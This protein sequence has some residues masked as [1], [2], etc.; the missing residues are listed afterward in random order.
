VG[1]IKL[2][3]FSFDGALFRSPEKPFWEEESWR[4]SLNSLSE[5]AVPERPS[6]DWWNKSVVDVAKQSIENPD[7]RAILLTQRVHKFSLRI[8]ELL[9]QSGLHFD[10]IYLPEGGSIEAFKLK[11]IRDIL[12]E[13]PSIRG[14]AIW[15]DDALTLRTFADWIESNGRSCIPHLVTV[16]PHDVDSRAPGR[17]A[18]DKITLDDLAG[19]PVGVV[20]ASTDG[21]V[22]WRK[23]GPS[24]S[25]WER[26]KPSAASD[27]GWG[28][29][30]PPERGLRVFRSLAAELMRQGGLVERLKSRIAS[31]VV[32]AARYKSKTKD[33]EGNVHYEY[34]DRQVANRH[35]QKAE[36]IEKL[37]KEVSDLRK[38]IKKDLSAKDAKTSLPA[39]AAALID[40]TCERVGNEGSA[41]EGHFGV[42]GWRKEHLTFSKGKAVFK[43]V[44]KSGVKHE[45]TVSDA[46]VVKLLRE[47]AKGK[48]DEDCLLNRDDFTVKPEHV[49][50]YLGAFDITA[51]DI[52]GFRANQ[53]M[54]RAL[55]EQ[56]RKGADLPHAR[57]KKDK[58]LKK[59]FA[60]ALKEVAGI[61]GHEKATLRSD[62]L[63]PGLEDKFMK[64]GTI[65]STFKEATKEATKT[66]GQNEDEAASELIKKSP[67]KKPPREDLKK[68][69]VD[70]EDSD[71]EADD[72]DLSRNVKKV[73]IRVAMAVRVALVARVALRYTVR[74][75]KTKPD[76]RT[77]RSKSKDDKSLLEWVKGKTFTNPETKK[78]VQFGS[79]PSEAQAR[80]RAKY[81]KGIE[82]EP[83]EEDDDFDPDPEEDDDF[84]DV[85]VE[86][87]ARPVEEQAPKEQA[88]N[89]KEQAPKEEAPKPKKEKTKQEIEREEERA[90]QLKADRINAE[91]Q[92]KAKYLGEARAFD[93]DTEDFVGDALDTVLESL[94]LEDSQE[95]VETLVSSRDSAIDEV[96]KG[97]LAIE[98]IPPDLKTIKKLLSRQKELS[99]AIAA[100]EKDPA[101]DPAE[102]AKS[103]EG[104][105]KKLDSN[106]QELQAD[107]SKFYV[108]AATKN[109]VRN[110]LTHIGDTSSPISSGDK[111]RTKK[112]VTRYR[113]MSSDDRA[114]AVE[115]FDSVRKDTDRAIE[116]LEERLSG[117]DANDENR[118]ADSE[119]LEGL[120][121][122]IGYLEADRQALE[123][124]SILEGDDL[125][126]SRVPKKTQSL[127]RA[128]K[129]SG[130]DVSD[131]VD[132]GLGL[133]NSKPEAREISNLIR[134]L[135]PEQMEAALEAIDPKLAAAWKKVND[136]DD[137]NDYIWP[138]SEIRNKQQRR[139]AEEAFDTYV[140]LLTDETLEDAAEENE[141]LKK[142]PVVKKKT[143]KKKPKAPEPTEGKPK[144][145]PYES[146]GIDALMDDLDIDTGFSDRKTSPKKGFVF[147][148]YPTWPTNESGGFDQ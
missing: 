14:V 53:E 59:E 7:V 74:T 69:R 40:E 103:I 43:Y 97:G 34:S 89:P 100:I 19:L 57:S 146:K 10:E 78:K 38:K 66:D 17:I 120:K 32:V 54:C 63:V 24:K 79:L 112:S 25:D 128:L 36:R 145:A 93:E 9:R 15:D 116:Q 142:A 61:V 83:D 16:S 131:I 101:V 86:E 37:R 117:G 136:A 133:A 73:A 82:N 26:Q 143:P 11:V 75:L 85:E 39:L 62:Y 28:P 5:P 144:D 30:H 58:I 67:K 84:E 45:K 55:R 1:P 13:E 71:L 114:G 77:A 121:N 22:A 27:D 12:S 8:K 118:A 50:E 96:A 140:E 126:N 132:S 95:F 47:L 123:L 109:A 134:K 115:S 98:G 94:S 29:T 107:F 130:I 49:N 92:E 108:H 125:K 6:S 110:P 4:D 52:R 124:S 111:E 60:E 70:T 35:D 127:V 41:K 104:F 102:K 91:L 137:S 18:A 31:A 135:H 119:K 23:T 51:K 72:D 88:L 64:D 81:N 48:A 90:Q 3:V 76:I 138:I 42:T 113:G 65:L 87:E 21:L 46:S 20:V 99:K 56:R 80:V 68:H 122:R 141:P 129:E 148:T 106:R 2:H 105:Q 33:D 44:G 139:D 147:T